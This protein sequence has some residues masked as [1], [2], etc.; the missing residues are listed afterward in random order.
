[1]AD[2]PRLDMLLPGGLVL[3]TTDGAAIPMAGASA[4]IA[5]DFDGIVGADVLRHMVVEID[6]E[7]RSLTLHDPRSYEYT[8]HGTALP[9]TY[10]MNY[11]P[12]IEGQ[13]AIPGRAPIP[14]KIILDTGAGGTVLTTPFVA[15]QRLL[16]SVATLP[17]PDMGAGGGES[18][19]HLARL[20]AL[21]I[22]PY[23]ISHPLAALS[24]DTVGTF[25]HSDF[26][27][28]LGGNILRRFTVII[29]YPRQRVIVEPNKTFADPFLADASGLVLKAEGKDHKTFVVTGM[30]P[31]SPAADAGMKPGDVITSLDGAS[32]RKFA[33]WEFED[34]LKAAGQRHT[35]TVRRG[36][37]SSNVSL[38][39][40]ALI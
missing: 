14:V 36:Q 35:L 23:S 18:V 34:A 17:S 27:V 20:G 24:D 16:T 1:M 39:L 22:G 29:D 10:W 31:H 38:D 33:L 2:I 9:F 5:R 7:R 40:R 19:K 12:L 21:R 8:G 37:S 3:S 26:D 15:K 13:L 6:Y 4:L 11:D 32:V 28:N 30:V 25:T